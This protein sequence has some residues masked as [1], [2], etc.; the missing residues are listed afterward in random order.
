MIFLFRLDITK[1]AVIPILVND[2]DF[3]DG[4]VPP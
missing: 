3:V 2:H 1:E 4:T